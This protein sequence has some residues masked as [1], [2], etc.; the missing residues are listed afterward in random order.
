M[1]AVGGGGCPPELATMGRVASC[2]VTVD[3]GAKRRFSGRMEA[4]GDETDLLSSLLCPT[5]DRCSAFLVGIA[6]IPKGFA[7]TGSR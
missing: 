1:G 5:R 4:M 7:V 2:P 6:T 3:T